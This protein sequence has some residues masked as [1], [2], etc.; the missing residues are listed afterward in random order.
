MVWLCGLVAN[1]IKSNLGREES[2]G[3]E[4][5]LLSASALADRFVSPPRRTGLCLL[6]IILTLR[7]H[8]HVPITFACTITVILNYQDMMLYLVIANSLLLIILIILVILNSKGK[9]KVA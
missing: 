4:E 5:G 3:H 7:L 9:G 1:F 6:Q 8:N 2:R